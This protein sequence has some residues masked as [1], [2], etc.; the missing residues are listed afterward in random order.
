M[1][2]GKLRLTLNLESQTPTL[3]FHNEKTGESLPPQTLF[4]LTYR[5]GHTTQALSSD[6]CKAELLDKSENS[7][8][9]SLHSGDFNVKFALWAGKGD[10]FHAQATLLD[11]P[12]GIEIDK[13]TYFTIMLAPDDF[14]WS[15]PLPE[16][17][18]HIPK[19]IM[20]L[21]QPIYL[22]SFFMG[23]EFPTCDNKIHEDTAQCTVY[24]GR[25]LRDIRSSDGSMPFHTCVVGAA[26]AAT[27]D[28]CHNA[29][30]AYMRTFARP[31]R[32]RL[33]F[34]SWYDNMLD[35]TS[36]NIADMVHYFRIRLYI[37]RRPFPESFPAGHIGHHILHHQLLPLA[38]DENP[39]GIVHLQREIDLARG[40]VAFGRSGKS[41]NH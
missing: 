11:A 36:D 41:D 40:F 8:T 22:R 32:F 38:T 34:N 12:E 13:L 27:Y 19:Y 23:G 10:F 37:I 26:D 6:M 21:G 3:C 9:L 30:F 4:T 29:F 33:Q 24:S 18:V 16:H 28:A 20:T 25:P 15:I 2:A 5:R 14:R 31:E 35:I 7:L 17:R 39:V 1:H